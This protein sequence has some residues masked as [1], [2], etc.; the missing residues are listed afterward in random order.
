[1]SFRLRD[2]GSRVS[3]ADTLREPLLYLLCGLRRRPSAC[4]GILLRIGR[5][6]VRMPGMFRSI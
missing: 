1:M 2:H 3:Y 4:G 6:V 5:F